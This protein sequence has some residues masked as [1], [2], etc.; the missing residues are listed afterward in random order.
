MAGTSKVSSCCIRHWFMEFILITYPFLLIN[1]PINYSTFYSI[2]IYPTHYLYFTS[3]LASTGYWKTIAACVIRSWNLQH[4]CVFQQPLME[5]ELWNR[6]VQERVIL[7]AVVCVCVSGGVASVHGSMYKQLCR[8]L[9]SAHS[10]SR[11]L[12]IQVCQAGF[13]LCLTTIAN[14]QNVV[15]LLEMVPRAADL[16]FK[17]NERTSYIYCWCSLLPAGNSGCLFSHKYWRSH[18]LCVHYTHTMTSYLE[19]QI[20]T[21]LCFQ[22]VIQTTAEWPSLV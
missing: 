6:R 9:L 5:L 2:I 10:V 20:D 7:V 3:L 18:V 8:A 21:R 15:R 4:T 12:T 14:W 16:N 1:I 13:S 17:L 19:W 11:F 22:H